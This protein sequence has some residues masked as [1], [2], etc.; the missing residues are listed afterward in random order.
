MVN[1]YLI[2]H[3]IFDASATLRLRLDTIIASRYVSNINRC[4]LVQRSRIFNV[5]EYYNILLLNRLLNSFDGVDY[6]SINDYHVSVDW[7]NILSHLSINDAGY[8][9]DCHPY[10]SINFCPFLIV[11]ITFLSFLGCISM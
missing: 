11:S 5:S 7:V 1:A 8:V 4:V 6:S 2:L 3:R 9:L 10:Y